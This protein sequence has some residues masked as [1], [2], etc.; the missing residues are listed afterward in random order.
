MHPAGRYVRTLSVLVASLFL[1]GAIPLVMADH[2]TAL[3][4]APDLVVAFID[5]WGYEPGDEITMWAI[6]YRHGEPWEQDTLTWGYR[7]MTFGSETQEVILD[8]LG[9]GEYRG[10]FKAEGDWVQADSYYPLV[11]PSD[12]GIGY[13][14]TR[15]TSGGAPNGFTVKPIGSDLGYSVKI[16]SPGLFRPG[17]TIEIIVT[18]DDLGAVD[19]FLDPT[20][21]L[22]IPLLLPPEPDSSATRK[23]YSLTYEE[24]LGA[25][26]GGTFYVSDGE[27]RTNLFVFDAQWVVTGTFDPG[28]FGLTDEPQTCLLRWDG[29][30]VGDDWILAP[31]RRGDPDLDNMVQRVGDLPC[32]EDPGVD[33]LRFHEL[34]TGAIRL[35]SAPSMV[36]VGR[37]GDATIATYSASEARATLVLDGHWSGSALLLE[38]ANADDHAD[39]VHSEVIDTS[40]YLW[41][42]HAEHLGDG[43][44]FMLFDLAADPAR[45]DYPAPASVGFLA[46]P[47]ATIYASKTTPKIEVYDLAIGGSTSFEITGLD[48]DDDALMV[49]I[50]PG[51]SLDSGIFLSNNGYIVYLDITR[52]GDVV[53]GEFTLPAFLPANGSY[54]LVFLYGD[55]GRSDLALLPVQNIEVGHSATNEHFEETDARAILVLVLTPM[56]FLGVAL[57][58]GIGFRV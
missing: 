28:L 2:D 40:S 39:L 11:D 51:D 13:H 42:P 19:L 25:N 37:S 20:D 14:P 48:D 44:S 30:L 26:H 5:E 4:A 17:E 36:E 23:G 45:E 47:L 6:A 50:Q 22:E 33:D 31:G 10:A 8:H 18:G 56:I 1:L 58:V 46:E 55:F 12:D 49:F 3:D 29:N 54:D 38:L 32:W 7:D 34:G 21:Y 24:T 53:Q 35:Y 43:V 9:H 41:E 16:E 57:I 27:N 15:I 52:E